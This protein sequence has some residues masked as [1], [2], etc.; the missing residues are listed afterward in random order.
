M[1][2]MTNSKDSAPD[3][4]P[5]SMPNAVNSMSA[6][7]G[8]AWLLALQTVG[9]LVVKQ[10]GLTV[11][12]PVLGMIFLLIALRWPSV[13]TAVASCAEFLL[14][15]LSLLFVPVGVGVM[16]HLGIFNDF[17]WQIA[18]VLVLSTWVGLSVTALA[19][20]WLQV[21]KA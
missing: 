11:P 2:I 17:G 8:F 21:R 16:T 15:H 12:G 19:L 4:E 20:R 14:A 13:Q 1:K 18:V 10:S 3:S 6:L 7:R 5:H 9:E